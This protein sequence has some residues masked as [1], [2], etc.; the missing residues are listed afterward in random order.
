MADDERIILNH[1]KLPTAFPVQ[2]PAE[3]DDSDDSDGNTNLKPDNRSRLQ[4]RRSRPRH[5]ALGRL[6]PSRRS[7]GSL[8]GSDEGST[9]VVGRNDEPDPLGSSDSIVRLLRHR[10]LPVDDDAKLRK[11]RFAVLV[12]A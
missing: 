1:Y 2:W 9:Q 6:A 12:D 5:S 11:Q 3:K 10:G 8:L 4:H 7:C